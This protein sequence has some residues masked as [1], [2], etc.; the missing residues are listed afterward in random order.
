MLKNEKSQRSL[1]KIK[2]L[3]QFPS[4]LN[5][6]KIKFNKFYQNSFYFIKLLQIQKNIMLKN[7]KS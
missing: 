4:R 6:L 1:G 5:S 3:F 7:E 2:I